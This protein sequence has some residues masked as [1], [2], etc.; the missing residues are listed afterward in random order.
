MR[1]RSLGYSTRQ[2]ADGESGEQVDAKINILSALTQVNCQ[3][4][5]GTMDLAPTS[6][7]EESLF[8]TV[9]RKRTKLKDCVIACSV[10]S[11]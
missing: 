2:E 5:S 10:L 11:S 1:R 4:L 9:D 6:N 7:F 3:S 8:A